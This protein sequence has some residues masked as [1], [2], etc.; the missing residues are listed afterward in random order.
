LSNYFLPQQD[1]PKYYEQFVG[2]IDVPYILE[3]TSDP[4]RSY[5]SSPGDEIGYDEKK[6]DICYSKLLGSYTDNGRYVSPLELINRTLT[7][8]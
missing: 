2:I 8:V 6:G 4:L 7:L 5:V 3:Y 1:D